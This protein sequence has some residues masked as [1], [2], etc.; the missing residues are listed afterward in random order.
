MRS[1]QF[2]G[3]D[4]KFNILLDI[5]KSQDTDL[6]FSF[7]TEYSFNGKYTMR[8]GYTGESLAFG[9]GV[10]YNMF[11]I[12]Y[13][14]GNPSTDGMLDPVHRMSFSFNFGMNRDEMFQIV[15]QLRLQE[16]ER[17]I[18]EIRESDKQKFIADHLQTAD[19][20]LRDN[21]Y[22][23]AIVEYQ[24]VIGV[25]PFHQHAKIMLDSSN[26]L[27]ENEFNIRQNSAVI[28][29]IDK[30][31]AETNRRFIDEHYEK[32]RLLL[33]Q[34]QYTEALIEFNIALDRDLNNQSIISAIQ[35]TRRRLNEDVNSL[36]RRGRE[37]FQNQN[38]SESLRL[39]SEARLL[40]NDDPEVKKEVDT[41]IERVKLQENIQKG[42]MLYDI[43][44]FDQALNLFETALELDPENQF[45]KQYYNKTK[46]ESS[47]ESEEMDPD[48][49]RRYLEGVDKFLLGQY[50]EA[51]RIWEDILQ[52]NPYNR[53]V[54]EA[55]NGA[56]D[57]LKRSRSQ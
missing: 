3:E 37:E 50:E 44:E 29:A 42:L 49:E 13:A 2:F 6:R 15:E 54:L 9:A 27:L 41:L 14:Y 20:Y 7:G 23:D 43:G 51:I 22:L 30:D 55:I 16:E 38:Y 10:E 40:S 19:E 35:T 21:N 26:I 18:T 32:G 31:R 25:D 39:L 17:I 8:L 45:I 53:K 36:V 5:D 12:D 46:S 4:N 1:I 52:D 11:Q 56:Q 48:T 28:A 24:Q 34:K 33:D 57:R 47:D